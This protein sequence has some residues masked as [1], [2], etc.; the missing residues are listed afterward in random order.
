MSSDCDSDDYI[1]SVIDYAYDPLDYEMHEPG[2]SGYIDN[3]IAMSSMKFS[4]P[5]IIES[6]HEKNGEIWLFKLL[7]S[8]SLQNSIL[9]WSND[10]NARTTH[11]E[12][13]ANELEIFTGLELVMTFHK[14]DNMKDY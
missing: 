2:K 4:Q 10:A 3:L 6:A 8:D 7:H 5:T 9:K 12:M 13:T 11:F 1:D 14:C